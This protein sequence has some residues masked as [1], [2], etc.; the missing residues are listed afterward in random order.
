ME[1]KKSIIKQKALSVSEKLDMLTM[2][3]VIQNLARVTIAKQFQL[4]QYCG[5]M[6]IYSAFCSSTT[7]LFKWFQQKQALNIPIHG[8]VIRKKKLY[9]D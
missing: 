1:D 9:C 3:A 6:R 7:S 8:T 5:Q 4:P 2:E